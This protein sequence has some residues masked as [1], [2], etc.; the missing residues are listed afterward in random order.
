MAFDSQPTLRDPLIQL[1]RLVAA[2][3][4]ALYAVVAGARPRR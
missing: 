1:R 2:D 3:Y 4:D